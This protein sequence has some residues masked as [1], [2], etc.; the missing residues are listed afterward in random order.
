MVPN[1]ATNNHATNYARLRERLTDAQDLQ[2]VASL[3]YWDQSTYMPL[4][5]A[6]ARARQSSTIQRMAH[7]CWTDPEIGRL[8]DELEP[9]AAQ[10]DYL[11]ADASLVRYARRRH[12]RETRLPSDFIFDAQRH[13]SETFEAWK[14]ARPQNDY[15]SVLPYLERTLELSRQYADFFPE[16]DDPIDPLIDALDYGMTAA[17]VSRIFD[18]LRT[19]LVPLAK[20]IL[21]A[22]E[23]DDGVLYGDFP[24]EDQKRFGEGLATAYGF[25]FNRGR[26]DLSAHPFMIGFS[27]D[28]V[29]ITTRYRRD[30][31]SEGLFST[32][33]ETGHA[34]YEL[35]IDRSLEATP[36]A[37]GTSMTIHESSSRLW[38]NQVGRSRAF[39][40]HF[41]PYLQSTFPKEL[42][43]V[44]LEEFYQAINRVHASLI[45]TAADEVTYN[46]HVMMRFDF[47][48]DLL[49]GDLKLADLP[50]A[51]RA[52][53]QALLGIS[54]TN[55][56]NGVLQDVHWFSGFIGGSF[57]GYTLG[58][59]LSAQLFESALKA[60]PSIQ[61]E[62]Q[63]GQFESLRSW[64]TENV[65]RYGSRL[66]TAEVIKKATGSPLKIEPYITYLRQKY[67]ELYKLE[68]HYS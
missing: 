25:D 23:I 42:N 62:I 30:K 43:R 36:L 52:Q 57:Q 17:K 34:L 18:E 58:N 47:E 3:L 20:Q 60:N 16:A 38:E 26:Q 59:I 63:N 55:D 27:I 45:R 49:S 46:L 7:R 65:Y 5:G 15:A 51:W 61:D 66:T 50:E 37:G 40:S 33:H 12:D 29:R 4:A 21:A 9:H 24:V 39:W 19:E 22:E 8:L 10:L 64:L 32:L 41:Y 1:H 6:P 28:D 56:K 14:V 67:S 48:R 11:S 44:S 53:S 2:S 35:G 31:L 13:F 68:V 54:P